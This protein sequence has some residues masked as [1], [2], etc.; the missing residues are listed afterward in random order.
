VAQAESGWRIEMYRTA[1][2]EIP[3]QT[4]LA[5]LTQ[6]HHDEAVALLALLREQGNLLRRPQSGVI[7]TGIFELRGHQVRIA[8]VFRPGRRIVLLDGVVKKRDR[9]PADFVTRVGRMARALE[10]AERRA[11]DKPKGGT[12]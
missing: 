9:L 6:P 12:P 1:T 5:N 11:Q 8:Y 10:E 7:R 3:V 2:G 4:F